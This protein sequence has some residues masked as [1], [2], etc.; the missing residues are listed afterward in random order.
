MRRTGLIGLG[1]LAVVALSVLAW[2]LVSADDDAKQAQSADPTA[3]ATTP[4]A[5]TTTVDP[6][7]PVIAPTATTIPPAVPTATSAPAPAVPTAT[8]R[9]PSSGSLPSSGPGITPA[10]S[11]TQNVPAPI[12]ALDVL[13]LE[14]FPPQ[15]VVRVRAGLPNGC[16]RQAGWTASRS[17]DVIRVTVMNNMPTGNVICTQI[18]GM[19]EVNGALGSDYESGRTYR[20]EVNDR[21][22]TFTA[23]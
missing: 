13:T 8:T 15:Y 7:A 11:G 5:S 4:P 20:I 12:D 21:I 6:T 22:T 19:Y 1:I 9:P 2:S 16:A 23:Q 18:Y 17:G 10:P 14:S 3:T